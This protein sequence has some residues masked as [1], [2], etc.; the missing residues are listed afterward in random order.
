[1]KIQFKESSI[2]TIKN[3]HQLCKDHSIMIFL[4]NQYNKSAEIVNMINNSFVP[5]V[6]YKKKVM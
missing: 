5:A 1:M 6:K 3:L 4:L 2:N